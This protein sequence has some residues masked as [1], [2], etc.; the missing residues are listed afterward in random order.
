[1]YL[2]PSSL[3]DTAR[4]HRHIPVLK[5]C[6][7]LGV[8]V[9]QV[10][11][12]KATANGVP[13]PRVSGIRV[14][15]AGHRQSRCDA[16]LGAS[17]P[18]VSYAS[19]LGGRCLHR[20][21]VDAGWQV[22]LFNLQGEIVERWNGT[23]IHYQLEYDTLGRQI[24]VIEK[25]EHAAGV[26]AQQFSYAE[27]SR[28]AKDR[29]Q[30]GRLI[31]Q[32]DNAGLLQWEAYDVG[33]RS[34]GQSRQ[35]MLEPLIPDWSSPPRMEADIYRSVYRYN[36]LGEDIGSLDAKGCERSIQVDR[37]G[38]ALAVSLGSPNAERQTVISGCE[39]AANGGL[40]RQRL[41]NGVQ[42]EISYCPTQGWVTAMRT[43]A[44]AGL[45]Q[46]LRQRHD[47]VGNVVGID[48]LA[49]PTRFFRNQRIEAVSAFGYDSL[50]QLVHASG[51]QV[52]GAVLG[53]GLAPFQSPQDPNQLE[54]YTQAFQYD[55]GGNITHI[56][57]RAASRNKT[58]RFYTSTSSNRTVPG[59]LEHEPPTESDIREAFDRHGNLLALSGNQLSW[60][61]HDRLCKVSMTGA[62]SSEHES[63]V[64]DVAGQRL[65]KISHFSGAPDSEVRY[66]S[67]VKVRMSQGASHVSSTV[68][69][70]GCE[71][72][73]HSIESGPGRLRSAG[74]YRY[75]LADLQGSMALQLDAEGALLSQETF[76]PFGGTSWWAGSSEVSAQAK[77]L[78][79]SAKE[80]DRTGLYYFG[81]RYY[82]PWLGRWINPDPA[83]EADGLN[84]YRMVRNNPMTLFD[85]HGLAPTKTAQR[86]IDQHA[87]SVGLPA[88]LSTF[89][90]VS[91]ALR[92]HKGYDARTLQWN[93][94]NSFAP[95][96]SDADLDPGTMGEISQFVGKDEMA[97]AMIRQ[98]STPAG[99][100]LDTSP[101]QQQLRKL[102]SNVLRRAQ[103]Y[104]QFITVTNDN[105]TNARP[106]LKGI[107]PRGWANGQ[108]WDTVPGVGA[109]GKGAASGTDGNETVIAMTGARSGSKIAT[110]HGSVN[111]VLHEFAHAID[112]SFGELGHLGDSGKG[113]VGDFLSSRASFR[114]AWT[115]DLA[116]AAGSAD[117]YYW[118]G[119]SSGGAEE[120]FAEGMADAYEG[121]N[122][123]NWPNIKSYLQ[124]K[125]MRLG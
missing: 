51:R 70:L 88:G 33:G 71:V 5:A 65:R 77:P 76:Y 24:R 110:G 101:V 116:G 36:A 112:R 78:R 66:L 63:Y 62:D 22:Q 75:H 59:R 106:G 28:Q 98:R 15:I 122:R 18:S 25:T 95:L 4:L 8:G 11:Y 41:G 3:A 109:V 82:A 37:A 54:N 87:Q 117:P 86:L 13:V 50:Y 55:A 44:S 118:Q 81:Q 69:L 34:T 72:E 94:I 64:Y 83:A 26:C 42:R 100:A 32:A 84:L 49:Q 67:Q 108:T 103:Q 53:P 58:H 1:M 92:T 74:H 14:D 2:H 61:S 29:N 6:D 12:L 123:R 9:R 119:G 97:G 38:Q 31:T 89:R 43:R 10:V 104:G 20:A 40:V 125:M 60:D 68:S 107:Q 120:A 39:Y 90:Q 121:G 111:L 124:S 27:V 17:L 80:R 99:I 115:A 35:F 102:P 30:C 47:Q 57:H 96:T 23:D 48:D 16:R 91:G 105:I 85:E 19:S 113:A 114:R 21:S 73:V 52:V 79:Y 93:E 7:A 46:D 56:E 45:L